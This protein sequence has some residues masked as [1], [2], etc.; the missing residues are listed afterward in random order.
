MLISGARPEPLRNLHVGCMVGIPFRPDDAAAIAGSF[1]GNMQS[2]KTI[3]DV[4]RKIGTDDSRRKAMVWI[5]GGI[6]TPGVEACGAQWK[7][8]PP[9]T[10]AWRRPE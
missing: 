4:A 5:S 7:G 8:M 10:S 3:E 1:L 6:P 9:T 2:F